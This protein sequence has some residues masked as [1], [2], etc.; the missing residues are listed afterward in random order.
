MIPP[1]SH[2]ATNPRYLRVAILAALLL[3]AYW[4][5]VAVERRLQRRVTTDPRATIFTAHGILTAIALLALLVNPYAVLLVVPA[6]ILWP[7]ARPGGWMRS[8]LP[9]YLGLVLVPVVL[10]YYATGLGLGAG[11]WWYFF[12]LL[13][14]RS[15]PAVGALLGVLFLS[16]A[17]VLAHALHTRG[18]APGEL[19]W[20]AV[21]RRGAE[22]MTEEE[23]A[24]Q[25]TSEPR[26]PRRKR[27]AAG[28]RPQQ[29]RRRGT[30][31]RSPDDE[32]QS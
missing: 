20:P 27:P 21:E 19:S 13:E 23:W 10:V 22:R 28:G 17:G 7:L 2:L 15:I 18:L 8:I 11:V 6:G 31:G 3:L 29:R 26:L 24:A 25:L 30:T 12:L 1:D 32:P 5:A 14:N 16:T 4:Y 9:A